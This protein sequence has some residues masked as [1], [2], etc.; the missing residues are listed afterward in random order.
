MGYLIVLDALS[1]MRNH[2]VSDLLKKDAII[3]ELKLALI[4]EPVLKMFKD[5]R[6]TE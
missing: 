6:E 5:G 3:S 2:Y 1:Q 4:S